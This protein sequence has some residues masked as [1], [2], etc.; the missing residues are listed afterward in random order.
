[1]GAKNKVYRIVPKSVFCQS[2]FCAHS[3]ELVAK[4]TCLIKESQRVDISNRLSD[5]EMD[6]WE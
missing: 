3:P 5:A 2:D 6:V 1:M 4:E